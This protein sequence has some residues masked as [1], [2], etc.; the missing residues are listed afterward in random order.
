MRY[1]GR[2]STKKSGI[3]ESER[4]KERPNHRIA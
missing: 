2:E 4:K 3:A 1:E